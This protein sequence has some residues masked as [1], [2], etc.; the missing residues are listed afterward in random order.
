VG[1]LRVGNFGRQS[2]GDFEST[3]F[4][5]GIPVG[6]KEFVQHWCRLSLSLSPLCAVPHMERPNRELVAD[7]PPDVGLIFWTFRP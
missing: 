1:E 2:P 5:E 3:P 6:R 7:V 4:D